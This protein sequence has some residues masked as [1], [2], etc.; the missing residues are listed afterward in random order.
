MQ[1]MPRNPGMLSANALAAFPLY[2]RC[3]NTFQQVITFRA[4]ARAVSIGSDGYPYVSLCLNPKDT[5]HYRLNR[6]VCEAFHGAPPSPE[7]Q[8]A[9]EN[10]N[11]LDCRPDNLSWKTARQNNA[12]KIRHG[13]DPVGV[14]NPRAKLSD[15]CVRKIRSL[16]ASG[17]SGTSVAEQFDVGATAISCIKLGKSWRHVADAAP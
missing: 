5:K 9:H 17:W 4:L 2:T 6:L 11:I 12:D 16:L 3:S 14:R 15:A 1:A 8:A 13:T 7:Y 10:G